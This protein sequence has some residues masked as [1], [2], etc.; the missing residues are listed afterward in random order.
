MTTTVRDR[1]LLIGSVATALGAVLFATVGSGLLGATAP[2]EAD[3]V[4]QNALGLASAALLGLGITG[5]RPSLQRVA[6][7]RLLGWGLSVVWVGLAALAGGH[8]L[9]IAAESAPRAVLESISLAGIPLT[10]GA[11]LIYP[12]TTLVGIALLRG[13]RWPFAL[14]VLLTTSLPL[15]LVGVP[16]GLALGDGALGDVVTWA[17]TEGQAGA[18][19]LA[20]AVIASVRTR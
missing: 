19:W 18:A 15:L 13:R 5:L 20:V 10:V 3:F 12:G 7:R 4:T 1:T 8:A 16:L 11:H 17:S 2:G 14:G 9:A 6:P